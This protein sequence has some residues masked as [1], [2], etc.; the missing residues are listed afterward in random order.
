MVLSK[1]TAVLLAASAVLAA[2]FGPAWNDSYGVETE[3]SDVLS[4]NFSM[5][6]DR[7]RISLTFKRPHGWF[8][9]AFPVGEHDFRMLGA[10]AFVYGAFPGVE[11][12]TDATV[13]EFILGDHLTPKPEDEVQNPDIWSRL[14]VDGVWKEDDRITVQF[15]RYNMVGP[16]ISLTE[17]ADTIPLLWAHAEDWVT[18]D[19]F[20][21]HGPDNRGALFLSKW[22]PNDDTPSPTER[23]TAPE[24]HALEATAGSQEAL[25]PP[26]PAETISNDT[27][28]TSRTKALV[29]IGSAGVC[30]FA[31][32]GISLLYRLNMCLRDES[33][34]NG[35]SDKPLIMV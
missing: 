2:G 27:A 35:E 22:D 19:F 5:L 11:N 15:Q 23:P 3:L 28:T 34:N 26:T 25:E 18:D 29:V 21:S 10:D 20:R 13:R 6:P 16:G 1:Q 17:Y 31:F 30:L 12:S 33:P 4:M 24:K 8:A 7:F 9:V 32:V 14:W